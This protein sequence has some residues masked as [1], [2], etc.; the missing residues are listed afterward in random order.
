MKLLSL[1][2]AA[3]TFVLLMTL[4]VYADN[5]TAQILPGLYVS[6]PGSNLS[7]DTMLNINAKAQTADKSQ[8]QFLAGLKS[9]IIGYKNFGLNMGA[10][11][12][13]GF[14]YR[15]YYA[16]SYEYVNKNPS[17]LMIIT[18]ITVSGFFSTLCDGQP[19]LYG[20]AISKKIF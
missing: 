10:I 9:Q 1:I 18:D 6:V 3:F 19:N 20:L 4:P 15:A 13:T 8:I 14:D 16:I 5:L 11:T 12:N 2:L 7:V 17:L